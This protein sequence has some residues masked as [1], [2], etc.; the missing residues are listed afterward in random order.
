MD[1]VSSALVRRKERHDRISG[2]AALTPQF[3]ADVYEGEIIAEMRAQ[4]D[5]VQA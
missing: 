3:L 5:Q 4:L 2:T 1:D